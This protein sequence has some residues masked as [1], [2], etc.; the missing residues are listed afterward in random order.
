LIETAHYLLKKKKDFYTSKAIFDGIIAA[1]IDRTLCEDLSQL[2][3]LGFLTPAQLKQYK[4]L[5][6][7]TGGQKVDNEMKANLKKYR[8]HVSFVTDFSSVSKQIEFSQGKWKSEE[9]KSKPLKKQEASKEKVFR[10]VRSTLANASG[11]PPCLPGLYTDLIEFEPSLNS[12]I[13]WDKSTQLRE[14]FLKIQKEKEEENN[15]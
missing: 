15:L 5:D 4:E 6:R 2:E 12:D 8:K 13:V 7:L 14:A 3:S 9:F 10:S 11:L 1:R